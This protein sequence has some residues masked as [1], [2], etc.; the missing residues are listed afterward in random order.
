MVQ[1]KRYIYVG[2]NVVTINLL[3]CV[4]VRGVRGLTEEQREWRGSKRMRKVD[5]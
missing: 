5:Y 3:V 1:I 4:T 2:G